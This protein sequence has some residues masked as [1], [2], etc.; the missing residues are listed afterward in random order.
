VGELI[1]RFL[2]IAASYA[3]MIAIGVMGSVHAVRRQNI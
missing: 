1:K 2:F 3:L